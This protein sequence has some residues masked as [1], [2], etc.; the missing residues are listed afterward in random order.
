MNSSSQSIAGTLRAPKS[1][2]LAMVLVPLAR[3]SHALTPNP[4]HGFRRGR[5]NIGHAGLPSLARRAGWA[6]RGKLLLSNRLQPIDHRLR[7]LGAKAIA[8]R[9]GPRHRKR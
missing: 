5:G 9:L 7:Q 4:R 8:A 3:G 2:L 1:S 6:D